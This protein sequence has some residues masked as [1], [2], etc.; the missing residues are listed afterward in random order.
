MCTQGV[1]KGAVETGQKPA[2]CPYY[3][4]ILIYQSEDGLT[5]IEVKMQDETVWLSQKQM[6]DL[7]QTSRTN[8]VEH[9]KT[10]MQKMNL[11]K[12]QPVGNSDSGLLNSGQPACSGQ[13]PVDVH[14]RPPGV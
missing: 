6:A 5:N 4:E 9:I 14:G 10:S 8:V 12:F 11:T 3:G 7:F 13:T 1:G 2:P